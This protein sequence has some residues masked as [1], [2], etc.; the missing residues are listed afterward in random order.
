MPGNPW[1]ASDPAAAAIVKVARRYIVSILLRWQILSSSPSFCTMQSASTH[2][3]L[4]PSRWM[5]VIA[6][7]DYFWQVSWQRRVLSFRIVF[8]HASS[9]CHRE[10]SCVFLHLF[11]S[12]NVAERYVRRKFGIDGLDDASIGDIDQ[13]EVGW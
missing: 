9:K 7:F 11:L 2:R 13:S 12:P 6:S 8:D 3:Y 1:F 4:Y 5:T 10:H